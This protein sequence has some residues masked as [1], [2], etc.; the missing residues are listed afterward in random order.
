MIPL[1]SDSDVLCIYGFI[2]V[3]IVVGS[4][5]STHLPNCFATNTFMTLFSQ[6][7]LL[8]SAVI[9]EEVPFS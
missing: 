8:F 6:I 9:F 4:Q 7:W 5:L 2:L 1:H 3:F